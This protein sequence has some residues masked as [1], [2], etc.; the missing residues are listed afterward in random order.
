MVQVLILSKMMASTQD[1]LQN[2]MKMVDTAYKYVCRAR[3]N[4]A[5]ISLRQQNQALYIP[6]YTENG[7]IILN[8]PRPEV[9]ED[10]AEAEVEDFS[11]QTSGESFTISGV[12][13]AD[14]HT[15]VFPPSKIIDLE[16]NLE[17]DHIQLSW[18]APGNVL[19]KRRKFDI[20]F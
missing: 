10:T 1:I 15:Q 12:P 7:Q 2:T 17:E 5:R 13:P 4:T 9:K 16:A 11:R 3:K 14:N 8:P 6:G 19:D 20:T 18:T